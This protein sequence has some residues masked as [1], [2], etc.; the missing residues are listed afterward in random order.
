MWDVHHDDETNN[1]EN[2]CWLRID[3]ED[4]VIFDVAKK[5]LRLEHKECNNIKVL[6]GCV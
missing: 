4:G 2:T 6:S 3:P 1:D 5:L